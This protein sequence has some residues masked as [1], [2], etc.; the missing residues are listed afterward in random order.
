MEWTATAKEVEAGGFRIGLDKIFRDF[1]WMY[2]CVV[3][4]LGGMIYLGAFAPRGY[5]VTDFTAI[6]PLA[7]QVACHILLPVSSQSLQRIPR[8]GLTDLQFALGLF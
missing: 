6:V 4:I 8:C 2:L 3:P 5:E 1:K 7:N